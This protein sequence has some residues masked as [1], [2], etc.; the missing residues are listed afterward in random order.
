MCLASDQHE[1][2]QLTCWIEL[3]VI[4][5]WSLQKQQHQGKLPDKK[6]INIM[7]MVM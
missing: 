2:Q 5:G 7:H 4:Q 6:K 3:K 1:P